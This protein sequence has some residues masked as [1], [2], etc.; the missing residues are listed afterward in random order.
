ML[1]SYYAVEMMKKQKNGGKIL[2]TSSMRG[3]ENS[4]K[5][6]I[7][8][9]TKSGLNSFTKSLA[10]QVAPFIQVNAV[11][12]GYVLTRAFDQA[13]AKTKQQLKSNIPLKRFTTEEEIADAFIFLA[14]SEG[15]TGQILYIDGGSTLL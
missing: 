8:A 4:G 7:Y 2:S 3:S 5:A 9:S 10:K 12:P 15:I 1:C 6:I 13:T 11:A 14:K